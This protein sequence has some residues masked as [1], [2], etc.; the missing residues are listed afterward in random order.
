MATSTA[1]VLQVEGSQHSA[2]IKDRR[3]HTQNPRRT[4]KA[5][6]EQFRCPRSNSH[7]L[8]RVCS[9]VHQVITVPIRGERSGRRPRFIIPIRSRRS[10]ETIR[11]L[12]SVPCL[13]ESRGHTGCHRYGD[14]EIRNQPNQRAEINKSINENEYDLPFRAFVPAN[15]PLIIF[16]NS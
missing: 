11:N 2:T 8:S 16:P 13:F 3:R 4:D 6:Q 7:F 10:S 15:S 5:Q 14:T 1:L 9:D 12:R